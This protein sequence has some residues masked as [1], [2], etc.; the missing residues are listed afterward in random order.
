[1]R[2]LLFTILF[3]ILACTAQGAYL[4]DYVE[5]ESLHFMWS[6]Y[7]TAGESITR[8]TDGT[9]LVYKDNT[10][11]STAGIT[12]TEDKG[13]FTGIHSC[14][15]DLSAD[16]FYAVGANY[17]VLLTAATVDGTV[18][19]A[20]IA[21]FSIENRFDPTATGVNVVEWDSSAVISPNVAGVPIVDTRYIVGSS[22]AADNFVD[23]YDGTGYAKTTSTIGTATDVTNTV[24]ANAVSAAGTFFQ[25]WFT[26][27]S[28]EVSGAEVSGSVILEI[29]KVVWDRILSGATHNINRSAG[30]ILRQLQENLGY[31]GGF[32]YVDTV[33]GVAGS[34]AFENG[35]AGNPVD[36][37]ADALLISAD[38]DVNIIRFQIAGRSDFTLTANSD[39]YQFFGD[40]WTLDLGGQSISGA[41]IHGASISGTATGAT[42]PTL[43]HC[44]FK[45]VTLPGG[46][47]RNCGL[48]GTFTVSGADDYFFVQCYSEVAGNAT[49]SLDFGAAVGS[50]NVNFRNYSGGVEIQN[51]NGA[52]SDTMSYEGR[53]QLVINA[54]CSGGAVSIRG[55]F[56]VTDN[57]SEVVT[58]S[59]DA[60]YDISQ[61]VGDVTNGI[62][63]DQWNGAAVAT[64][65]VAGV[66]EVDITHVTGSSGAA[67]SL[68]SLTDLIVDSGT[69]QGPGANGNHI[70]LAADSPSTS[71][72][73]DPAIILIVGGTGVKQSRRIIQY[74]G[75][76]KIATVSRS[77]KTNPAADSDYIIIA[78]P[79]GLH[80]NEGD[81][82][83]GGNTTVT[84]N[85]LA[86][87]EDNTYNGQTVFLVSG[88]GEDQPRVVT[89]YVGSTRLATVNRAWDTN[90]TST[91]GY[92][93]LPMLDSANIERISGDAPS[94]GSLKDL[95]DDGYSSATNKIQGVLLTDTT[96]DITNPVTVGDI[97][98]AAMALFFSLD[99]GDTSAGAV[100]GSVVKEIV[101]NAGGSGLT[102]ESLAVSVWTIESVPRNVDTVTT[103][104]TTV[105]NADL[106]TAAAIVSALLS[107]TI[108]AGGVATIQDIFIHVY[109]MA[110]GKFTAPGNDASRVFTF[111]DDDDTTQV[112]SYTTTTSGRTPN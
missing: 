111:F 60:R 16:A 11:T 68:K 4:G 42:T 61:P 71:D 67:S 74:D 18:V 106:V 25:D 5:D 63:V 100:S 62:N 37:W 85:D 93:M 55:L 41:F 83:G 35:T 76:T 14:T 112:T 70:Q 82:Q 17:T 75:T 66:P 52:G 59:D 91:T 94:A 49:P 1:M 10:T 26:V 28:G 58:L 27:D 29:S 97:L 33:D 104:T 39:G 7:G 78:D 19:N 43:E 47:F 9:I 12:D 54:N 57:A 3:I 21:D 45:N 2:K 20:V 87:S 108:T 32:I 73:Y 56:T 84:L 31:E 72:I 89:D 40:S 110:R 24:D 13:G 98:Q 36:N 88:T 65:S 95:V 50:T 8:A 64:P 44:M 86:S 109:A 81:A 22:S 92:L 69:A 23:D 103:V 53:G 80:V 77:W 105:T 34:V 102:T 99:S 90:P 51:M 48:S 96:T 15:I 30:K 107:E 46:E 38:P 6:T 101:D 79:G